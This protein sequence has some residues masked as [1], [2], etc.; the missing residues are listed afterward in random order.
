ML[1]VTLS[2]SNTAGALSVGQ[3]QLMQAGV[4]FFNLAQDPVCAG[5]GAAAGTT[6]GTSG[7]GVPTAD[8]AS[9]I[10]AYG[11]LAFDVGKANGLPYDAILAQATWESNYGR[12]GLN[13]QANNFFGIKA[14]PAWTGPTIT[15]PT[16]EEVNGAL[17][18]VYAQFVVYSSP[19]AGFQGY[20]DF[21][22]RNPRYANA[23]VFNHQH[24]PVGYF[25]ALKD[26][27][28]A[29]DSGYVTSLT[30]RLTAAQNYIAGKGVL[31]P[32]SQVVY[33][34]QP[35]GGPGDTPAGTPAASGDGSCTAVTTAAAT[36]NASG[37]VGVALGEL[38][39]H[40]Q[41]YTGG[42][43]ENWCADFVSWVFKAAGK[44]FTPTP[45]VGMVDGWQITS[46]DNMRK[47]L[48]TKGQFFLKSAN[49]P[50]PQ[51]GDIV[52]YKNG[53]SHTNIVVEAN[54]Y[55]VKT[56]GGNQESNSM[57]SSVVSESRGAFDIRNDSTVTGWGRLP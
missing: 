44:P 29:T 56:V 45:G 25:Q 13:K 50:A 26:A 2:L 11:Q 46:V 38:G 31:T 33:D 57:T 27:G 22:K 17:I 9:F 24:D 12:S 6:T 40:Y 35:S 30:G 28:Y 1:L 21:L 53:M 54:G 15:M 14:Y 23:G 8:M 49:A 18:T 36:G 39:N 43:V 47:Y 19:E 55:M 32:E 42:R 5:G 3:K 16:H 20:A 10:D 52:I 34:V 7:T 37:V 4:G 48:E 41:K 51:P